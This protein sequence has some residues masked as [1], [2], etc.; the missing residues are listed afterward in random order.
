MV[1]NSVG[2]ALVVFRPLF[3]PLFLTLFLKVHLCRIH[4]HARRRCARHLSIV[5]QSFFAQLQ[6]M[7][8]KSTQKKQRAAP[9]QQ[10]RRRQQQAQRTGAPRPGPRRGHITDLYDPRN[11]ALVPTIVSEG[12]AFPMFGSTIRPVNA[13][14]TSRVIVAL[15]NNGM[16]GTV[17]SVVTFGGNVVLDVSTIPLLSAAA[18]NGGPTSARAMKA[19]LSITNRTQFL[20]QGGQITVLN[21]SQRVH[22]DANASAMTA[23][24]WGSLANDIIAHPKARVYSGAD[25]NRSKTF[26]CHPLDASDYLRYQTFAGAQTADEFWSHIAVWPGV[27]QPLPTTRPMSTIFLV[28]ESPQVGN[29]YEVKTRAG[30]Y[31][32]W[33]LDSVAGQAHRQVPTAPASVVNA[34]RDH[35]EATAHMPRAAEEAALGVGAAALGGAAWLARA[36]RAAQAGAAAVGEGLELAAPLLALV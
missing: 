8:G 17:M 25:F 31:T 36:T 18:I 24:Q 5:V 12:P 2:S 22:I 20:N 21:A 6:A 19:G 35:A 16:S 1:H 26:I 13:P 9:K 33:P 14:T 32:R 7:P 27:V 28:F 15:T 3:W 11:T 10:P 34:H 29:V 30:Y 4:S 23:A